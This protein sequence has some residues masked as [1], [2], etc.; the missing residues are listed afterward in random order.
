VSARILGIVGTGAIGASIGMRA[1]ANGWHVLGCDSD[2]EALENARRAGA[3]D[4]GASRDVLY[5]DAHVLVLA[6]H[7]DSVLTEIER[8]RVRP[9]NAELILDAASVKAAVSAAGRALPQ[10]V[11][12]HPMAGTERTGPLAA[13]ADLFEGCTWAYVSSGSSELDERARRFIGSLG[14]NPLAIDAAEHDRL[15]ARTSHLPQLVSTLFASSLVDETNA[16]AL[17]ALCGP[18]AR[19]MRRLG[20]S[21]FA[22]WEPILRHNATN[23]AREARALAVR[24]NEAADA[25]ERGEAATIPTL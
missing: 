17:D 18:A 5:H 13:R 8:L 25:L 23:V 1:R 16:A 24:L 3:I 12:S 7:L 11:A 19:E 15:V 6:T 4:A 2:A 20:R 14:A 21:S 10:F 9:V 22:M